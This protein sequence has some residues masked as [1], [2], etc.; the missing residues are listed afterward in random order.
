MMARSS[1]SHSTQVPADSMM[2]STPQVTLPPRR[3]AM[4]GMVPAGPR[5][6]WT[7][8]PGPTHWSSIPPVP[9]VALACPG[10]VHPCPMSDAC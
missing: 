1:R 3:Q 10:W 4:M 6:I 2:A 9:K 7:G 8:R 5:A